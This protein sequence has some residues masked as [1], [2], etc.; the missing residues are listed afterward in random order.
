MNIHIQIFE[1]FP[2][3]YEVMENEDDNIILIFII[4]GV[5]HVFNMI[6]VIE[7]KMVRLYKFVTYN[8]NFITYNY[9]IITYNYN[10]ITYIL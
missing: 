2:S 4:K 3:I 8:Y 5:Q 9:N 10:F 7:D 6:D 1:V